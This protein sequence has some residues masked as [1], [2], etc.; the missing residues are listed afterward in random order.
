MRWGQESLELIVYQFG[1][2]IRDELA[3]GHVEGMYKDIEWN[4]WT[5]KMGKRNDAFELECGTK[6]Q[7]QSE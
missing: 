3:Q 4:L 7:T 2:H 5:W 6:A 1:Y